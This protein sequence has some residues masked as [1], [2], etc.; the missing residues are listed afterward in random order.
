VLAPIGRDAE[1]ACRLLQE[2]GHAAQ[3]TQTIEALA[4]QIDEGSGMAI[5][6]DEA[7]LPYVRAV[8]EQIQQPIGKMHEA[9]AIDD[10]FASRSGNVHFVAFFGKNFFQEAANVGLVIDHQD[11]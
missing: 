9:G 2:A 7:L 5:I 4:K 11:S 3:V 8:W 10:R 6:A 1:V